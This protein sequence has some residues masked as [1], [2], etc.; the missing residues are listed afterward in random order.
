[1]STKPYL[2]LKQTDLIL[3]KACPNVHKTILMSSTPC[4][5]FKQTIDSCHGV[6]D[7]C[8]LP[9]VPHVAGIFIAQITLLVYWE[10]REEGPPANPFF[11]CGAL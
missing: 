7:I 3:T 2:N 1:M 5:I 10:L 4:P 9:E 11:F 6:Y 8:T